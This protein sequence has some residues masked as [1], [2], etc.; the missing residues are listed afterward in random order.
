MNRRPNPFK[1]APDT[2]NIDLTTTA[3]T[4]TAITIM[5]MNIGGV[6]GTGIII[7]TI[8][9]ETTTGIDV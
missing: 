3:T 1:S 9:I 8:A 4:V 6:G 7:G 5:G 2:N